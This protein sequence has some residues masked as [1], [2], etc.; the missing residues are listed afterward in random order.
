MLTTAMRTTWSPSIISLL[1][2]NAA[3]A[4]ADAD[5]VVIAASARD[6][7][8]GLP[9]SST[10]N[11]VDDDYGWPRFNSNADFDV[12]DLTGAWATYFK[13]VYGEL[14]SDSDNF[15]S[16][17]GGSSQ[18]RRSTSASSSSYPICVFGAFSVLLRANYDAAGLNDTSLNPRH[19][20]RPVDAN[21]RDGD[22]F[23]SRFGYQIYHAK[24]APLPDNSWVEVIHTVVPTEV[25]GMWVWRTP[26]S[27]VFANLGRTIVFPTP[28]DMSKVHREAIEFF[29][30]NCSRPISKMWP[31]L[32]SD[33]F[34][35]CAR[36]KGYDSVQ[37][38]P[39]DGKVPLGDFGVPG[40]TEIVLVTLSGAGESCGVSPR[41]GRQTPLRTGWGASRRCDCVRV[42]TDARCGLMPRA[43]FP[44]NVIGARPPMCGVQDQGHFWD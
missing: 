23:E 2:S 18:K 12:S 24:W 16:T 13:S 14:P 29:S 15:A 43:P 41:A 26:G 11:G 40:L 35:F 33:V 44:F 38:K 3:A 34:G 1:L 5:A 4:V 27:G 36:E 42:H 21:L 22:L 31:Q 10:C 19:M 37:F 17:A 30:R 9:T 28:R 20:L 32:E 39:Q 8:A 7:A 6:V 25:D